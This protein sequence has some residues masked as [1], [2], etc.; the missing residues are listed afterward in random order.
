MYEEELDR[1]RKTEAKLKASLHRESDLLRQKD[2]LILQK[3]T[4]RRESEHRLLNGL[5][6]ITSLLAA[7][8]R[9]TLSA[10][11][12]AQLANA[13]NRVTTL[14]RIHRHLNTL[15]NSECVEFRQFLAK[16][17][18]DISDMAWGESIDR[19]LVV[20]GT[21]V[22]IPSSIA[23]PLGFIACELITNSIKHAK[24]KIEVCLEE[25]PPGCALS[26]TDDG[27]GLP[28]GF[29]PTVSNGLGMKLIPALVKQ[30]G[31]ELDIGKGHHGQGTKFTVRFT[32]HG[33]N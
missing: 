32:P 25:S 18:D 2:E 1:H 11:A 3:D 20:K 33:S 12:A 7:Q 30:I 19:A 10:E 14:A 16:L 9:A 22:Q 28:Q 4:L 6:L 21:K 26:I 24:G 29:D 8:S 13:A 23:V 27:P 31:G 15:D 5:Q 17:C